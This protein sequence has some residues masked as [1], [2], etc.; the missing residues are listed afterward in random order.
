ME[1]NA[2]RESDLPYHELECTTRP[3]KGNKGAG[4]IARLSD[5]TVKKVKCRLQVLVNVI[6]G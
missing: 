3:S 2:S 5:L 1:M 6:S 4:I